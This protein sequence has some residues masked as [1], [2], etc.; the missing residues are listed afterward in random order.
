M[1]RTR[2]FGLTG[3]K[4][5]DDCRSSFHLIS[6]NSRWLQLCE[7]ALQNTS[8]LLLFLPTQGLAPCELFPFSVIPAECPCSP[9]WD[10]SGRVMRF[11]LPPLSFTC[12][13]QIPGEEKCGNR[14]KRLI[15][16]FNISRYSCFIGRQ[17][18]AQETRS[19]ADGHFCQATIRDS[20][21]PASRSV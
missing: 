2:L 10:C 4:R 21:S 17:L 20:S 1:G 11:F 8:C 5:I 9:S 19:G 6:S 15:V 18:L 3:K 12:E 14:D 16:N 7:A 13:N